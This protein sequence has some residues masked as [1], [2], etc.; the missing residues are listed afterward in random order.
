VRNI[1]AG[2]LQPAE[3]SSRRPSSMGVYSRRK[4][5]KAAVQ[6]TPTTPVKSI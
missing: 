5:A 2:A 1:A 3:R 4:S 6:A